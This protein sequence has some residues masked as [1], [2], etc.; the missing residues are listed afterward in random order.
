MSKY[1]EVRPLNGEEI[2]EAVHKEAYRRGLRSHHAFDD[3]VSQSCIEMLRRYRRGETVGHA[4]NCVK[5]AVLSAYRHVTHCRTKYVKN[6]EVP[7]PSPELVPSATSSEISAEKLAYAVI[8]LQKTCISPRYGEVLVNILN[9]D[10]RIVA[11]RKVFKNAKDSTLK[12]HLRNIR[13][14]IKQKNS[15]Y[16]VLNTIDESKLSAEI[17]DALRRIRMEG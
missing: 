3:I 12:V 7:L 13:C 4:M 8:E 6:L 11:C 2:L 5:Y 16:G 15:P 1:D 10:P 9:G 17:Q 14:Q